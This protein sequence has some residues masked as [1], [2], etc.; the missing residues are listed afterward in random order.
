MAIA[1]GRVS[2]SP[3]YRAY[4]DRFPSFVRYFET[5]EGIH[6]RPAQFADI[7]M[8]G[9]KLISRHPTSAKVGDLLNLEFT[10]PGTNFTIRRAAQVVRKR[11]EF[12]FAVRF[13]HSTSQSESG[14]LQ[15]AIE[16]YAEFVKKMVWLRPY[17]RFVNWVRNHSQ[18]LLA[19]LIGMLVI[20]GAGVWIYLGSD[21]YQGRGMR[22]W[23]Q[24]IPKEWFIQYHSK[25]IKASR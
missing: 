4:P 16:Q 3:R 13:L 14:D 23:G 1:A 2:R 21:E 12:V 5:A 18:G 24:D 9:M 6:P 10:L 11:S 17:V 25:S 22:A 7:S 19:S 20:G 8:S 15:R